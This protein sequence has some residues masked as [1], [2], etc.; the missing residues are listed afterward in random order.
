MLRIGIAVRFEPV[1]ILHGADCRQAN[2]GPLPCTPQVSIQA[3]CPGPAVR[4]ASLSARMRAV[5]GAASSADAEGRRCKNVSARASAVPDQGLRLLFSNWNSSENSL[6]FA[7]S[8]LR[9]KCSLSGGLGFLP[10]VSST[11]SNETSRLP[12]PARTPNRMLAIAAP[13]RNALA[14]CGAT[15]RSP[16]WGF[17][18]ARVDKRG[19]AP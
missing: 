3:A 19:S 1:E 4:K 16:T 17:L 14:R 8:H 11:S 5:L 9:V 10:I 13:Q 15:C 12:K 18:R 7:F 6:I 2:D